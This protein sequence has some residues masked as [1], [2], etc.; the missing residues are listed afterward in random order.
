LND[1]V[2]E[3]G[4]LTFVF[5]DPDASGP[6]ARSDVYL[7]RRRYFFSIFRYLCR[8]IFF[9]RFLTRDPIDT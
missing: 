5:P 8:R 3:K 9:R 6:G 2:Y 4:G 7:F 1:A